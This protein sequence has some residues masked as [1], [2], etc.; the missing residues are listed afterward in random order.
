MVAG[1]FWVMDVWDRP[2]WR[3]GTHEEGDRPPFSDRVIFAL[4]R[5]ADLY[6]LSVLPRAAKDIEPPAERCVQ[7][8]NAIEMNC[9]A[10]QVSEL[11]DEQSALALAYGRSNFHGTMGL[12]IVIQAAEILKDRSVPV[13][14]HLIGKLP[15]CDLATI[16]QSRASSYFE[17]HGF[18]DAPR[19]Q[20][21]KRTHV[22]LVPYQA[23]EDLSYIFPIKVLEHL[24]QGNAV[25]V[26]R[27]PGLCAMVQHEYNGL[28]VE[29]GDP[30]SLAEAIARLHADRPL[31]K[32]LANNALNS[33]RKFDAAEKNRRIFET[34][35]QKV[36]NAD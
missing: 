6:L 4:M 9:V 29:P 14:I 15:P 33:V 3:T 31:L 16:K 32:R 34:I 36:A 22:G 30:L 11:P 13:V 7:L 19:L 12:N 18:T 24:S 1:Y 27:L 5:H 35:L 25:I 2:R 20:L 10:N 17:I 26:S 28:V 23:F 21:F 8:Y